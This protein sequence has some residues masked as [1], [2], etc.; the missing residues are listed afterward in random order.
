MPE[1]LKI[2]HK[3]L[4]LIFIR[5]YSCHFRKFHEYWRNLKFQHSR[6][7]NLKLIS[8]KKYPMESLAGLIL[9]FLSGFLVLICDDQGLVAVPGSQSPRQHSTLHRP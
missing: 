8:Q 3:I 4:Q 9:T 7:P 6:K 2:I 1:D 5:M